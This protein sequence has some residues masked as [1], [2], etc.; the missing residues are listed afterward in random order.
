MIWRTPSLS[1]EFLVSG[2]FLSEQEKTS[3]FQLSLKPTPKMI[4]SGYYDA[5]TPPVLCLS[6]S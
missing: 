5:K 1:L 4:A 2:C 3:Y 6:H